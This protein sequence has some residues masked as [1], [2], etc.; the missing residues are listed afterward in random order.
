[1]I[2]NTTGILL[3]KPHGG[4]RLAKQTSWGD[5]YVAF[6]YTA[7]EAWAKLSKITGRSVR[8]LK[9]LQITRVF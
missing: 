9:S 5:E 6:A 1:M 8:E 3:S 7:K 4:F 2:S